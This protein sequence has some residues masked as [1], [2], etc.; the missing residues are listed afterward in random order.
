MVPLTP[1]GCKGVMTAIR[2]LDKPMTVEEFLAWDSGDDFVWEL[3]GG[4]PVLRDADP[5]TGQAAPSPDHGAITAALGAAIHMALRAL[6]HPCRLEVGSGI[7]R[8]RRDRDYRVPDLMVRCGRQGGGAK[9]RLDA[10]GVDPAPGTRDPG[11]PVLVIEVLSPVNTASEMNRKH[12]FFKTI[13]SIEEIVEVEQAEAAC[14]LLRRRGDIWVQEQIVGLDAVLRL[15]SI[16]LE[17]PLAEIYATTG[18]GAA[19]PGATAEDGA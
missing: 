2:K 19:T 1:L 13:D 4:H 14:T 9:G 7:G 17:V 18:V 16:G 12:A 6:D 10:E 3:V 11:V 8:G 5:L 15:D